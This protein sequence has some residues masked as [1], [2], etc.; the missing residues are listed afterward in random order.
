MSG[1]PAAER[2]TGLRSRLRRHGLVRR[3]EVIRSLVRGGRLRFTE[4]N[5][6]AL[7]ETGRAGLESML[8]AI[9]SARQRVHLESYILRDDA[10]GRRFLE[11]LRE[12]AAAAVE[13]RVLYDAVGSRG[14]DSSSLAE[15]LAAGADVIAFNPIVRLY[16]RFAPRR[17]D[18]RKILVV[19]GRVGFT[20]GLNIG[21]EYVDG[22]VGESG[23]REREWRD[24]HLRIEG[25]AVRDLEAVF[26]ES[27][28]RADGPGL[29]W[30]ALLARAPE[31]VGPVR[32]AVL[33]DGPV[34]RRRRMRELILSA[35]D[36]ARRSVQI[37]SPYFAPGGRVLDALSRASERG[38]RVELLLAGYTDHP[39]LRR[40]ARSML[41]RLLAAGVH[42][43]EYERAMLHSKLAVFDDEWAVVGTSN[44]DRQSFEHN[45]E[46]NVIVEGGEIP[47]QLRRRFEADVGIATRVDFESLA[48]RG[49]LE[50]VVD[51]LASLVL[52]F[53]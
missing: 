3:P 27:W 37:E 4:G 9:R 35:L 48:A 31:P 42:V 11:A 15:L 8:A 7:F 44:L 25:P 5:R 50:R 32:C 43:H 49:A 20:G 45:Y 51:R 13:V 24:A 14:L 41:P 40:A 18:H 47:G 29:A 10:M 28:F 16:P 22:L 26:L 1:D 2:W 19:D 23:A 30:H 52:Y 6:V 39:V 46:V 53:V 38:V 21:D 12:R 33:P 17:R 34:Y 36:S